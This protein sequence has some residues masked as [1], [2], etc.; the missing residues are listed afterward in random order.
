[1]TPGDAM[2]K[3]ILACPRDDVVRLVY[4]DWLDEVQEETARAGAAGERARR[5]RSEGDDSSYNLP[6]LSGSLPGFAPV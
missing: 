5:E 2:L 6:A 4:A 3:D 1:M